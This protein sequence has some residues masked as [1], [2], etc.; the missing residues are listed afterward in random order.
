MIKINDTHQH[1]WDLERLNLPWLDN[2]PALKKGHLSADYLKAAEG[3][4][5]YRT[6]YMEVDVYADLKQ[7][8]IEDILKS[9]IR[10]F[11]GT[12]FLSFL[13]PQKLR[14]KIWQ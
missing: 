6:V 8:E 11:M 9:E 4:G 1:L 3:T 12:L 14:S 10:R 2:V 13:D 5:I 7:K